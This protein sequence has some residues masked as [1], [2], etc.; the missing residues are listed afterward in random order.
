MFE[1]AGFEVDILREF[2][3]GICSLSLS[4]PNPRSSYCCDDG[5]P[6]FH[7]CLPHLA[8]CAGVDV[9][10]GDLHLLTLRVLI[11]VLELPVE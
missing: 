4:P 9:P 1:V 5:A 3:D 7:L 2:L 8:F 6:R 10:D 11:S